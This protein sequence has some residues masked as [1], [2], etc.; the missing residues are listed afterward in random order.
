ML[1]FTTD[2]IIGLSL[3]FIM[4]LSLLGLVLGPPI[5]ALT[6][7]DELATALYNTAKPFCHQWIYRSFCIFDNESGVYIDNCIPNDYEENPV[8]IKTKYT[9]AINKWDGVFKYS[10]DQLGANRAEIV[11][12]DNTIGYKFGMCS[13]DTA[14]YIGLVIA[15]LMYPLL[16]KKFKELPPLRYLVIGI[17]PL[18]A[19]GIGQMIGLWESNN[20]S[21]FITGLIAGLFIGAYLVLVLPRAFNKSQREIKK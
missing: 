11:L 8:V 2:E 7:H 4:A 1:K 21:R 17:I 14:L 19:D 18:A 15:G 16:R 13:R 3:Y 20:T 12:K 6:H 5:A 9:L 10:R